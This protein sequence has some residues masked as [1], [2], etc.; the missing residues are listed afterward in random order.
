MATVDVTKEVVVHER[1]RPVGFARWLFTTNHKDIGLLYI[2]TSFGFFLLGGALAMVIRAKLAQPGANLIG[3]E[4]YDSLFT[5]HGTTMIFLFA[6]PILTGFGNYFVPI[7]I[8]ADDM[9][10]PRINNLGFWLI[11]PAGAAIWLGSADIGWTGYAPLSVFAPGHGVDLWLVGLQVLG[12][13]SILSSINFIVTIFK[14]RAP[15]ITFNN[16]SLFVWS[17][18]ATSFML[19][20]AAPALASALTMLFFDRNFGTCFFSTA[21]ACGANPGDPILW[22]HLFW[23]F[24]HPEV[25]IMILPAMGIISEVLPK[26]AHKPIFG[27]KDIAW[28]TVAIAV[29]G[30]GVWA[31]HMFTTGID[32]RV[33]IPFMLVTLAIAVPSGIKIFNWT[34]TLWNGDLLLKTPMLYVIG[35]LTTFTIGGISGVFMASIP[36]DYQLQDTYFVVAHLHYVLFGGTVMG[37]FAGAYFWYPKVTG[38]YYNEGLGKLHFA[39]TI[40]GMNIVFFTMH[41]MGLEGMPRRIYDYSLILP[42]H[43]DLTLQNQIASVGAAILGAGQL[44]FFANMLWSLRTGRPAPADPWA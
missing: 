36:V 22:Q 16:V 7:L 11:P 30:Y 44:I 13:S 28:S 40:I 34:T 39:L 2:F 8:G 37:I 19:L 17:M 21:A 25:Y 27:Y 35:F 9:A 24:G 6:V 23:F 31:H 10:F 26:M 32:L 41:F 4:T 15:G 38:R 42:Y 1:P 20:L 3:P 14:L 5:I 43:P 18:L 33:R 29:M 12:I